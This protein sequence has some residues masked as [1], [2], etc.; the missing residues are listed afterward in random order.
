MSHIL[1]ASLQTLIPRFTRRAY[2]LLYFF[3]ERGARLK[4]DTWERP[5]A[6]RLWGQGPRRSPPNV[7]LPV[8]T[9]PG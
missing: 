9:V 1:Y 4:I 8:G 2:I 5:G 7:Q 3:L 6:L